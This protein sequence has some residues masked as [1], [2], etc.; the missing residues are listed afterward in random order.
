MTW[1][2]AKLRERIQVGQPIQ[3]P[4]SG[5]GFDFTFNTL[6]TVWAGLK[7]LTPGQY[8]RGEQIGE[9]ITGEFTI[10]RIAVASLGMEF[11]KG[12]ASGFDSMKDLNLLKSDYYIFLQQSSTV[13]GRL[14]RIR[15][16]KDNDE[17]RE[18]LRVRVEEIEE[19][20]TG[21]PS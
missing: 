7:P 2:V 5:G 13:K 8:V 14:F 1:L 4:N 9:D 10:R 21:F 12:F 19:K 11:G 20:G 15:D 17:R 3:T 6:L 16:V 18:Y